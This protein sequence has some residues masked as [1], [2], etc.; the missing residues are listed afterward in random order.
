LPFSGTLGTSKNHNSAEAW[1]GPK[2]FLTF[3][4]DQPLIHYGKNCW[5]ADFENNLKTHWEK[6]LAKYKSVWLSSKSQHY[7]SKNEADGLRHSKFQ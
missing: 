2:N 5:E 3:A 6:K 1:Q 4:S 7:T